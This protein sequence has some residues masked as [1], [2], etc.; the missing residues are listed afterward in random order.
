M[1]VI[2]SLGDSLTCGMGVGVHVPPDQTWIG[3][4]AAGAPENRLVQLAEPGAR[5]RDVRIRQLPSV[6]TADVVT[7][8]A[9]LNDIARGGFDA[10]QLREDMHRIVLD[11]TRQ[12]AAVLVGRLHDP[13]EMLPLPEW[14]AAVVRERVG[15]VNQIVDEA[16]PWPGVMTLDLASIPA[17]RQ[18]G[19]WS[20]DR[21]H[22]SRAGHQAI[23]A[24]AAA[25]LIEHGYG[26]QHVRD[27]EVPAGASVGARAW[28]AMRYG[29]PYLA[30]HV[31]EFGP[32]L[33]SAVA[34]RV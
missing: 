4:L 34:T 11:L 21:I 32:P 3:L 22:P 13:G 10:A 23:A 24:T 18:P 19:G 17:L 1:T 6:P 12:G 26:W 30:I 25:V 20:T 14:L 8:L 28:W 15:A 29:I 9:G 2:V 27:P 7:M 33:L 16:R 31:T 5:I